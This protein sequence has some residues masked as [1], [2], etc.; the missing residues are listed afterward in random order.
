MSCREECADVLVLQIILGVAVV[1]VPRPEAQLS[2][3][4]NN[5]TT[6]NILPYSVLAY[7][8]VESILQEVCKLKWSFGVCGI[9][10][11]EH[12]L[13]AREQ[14]A[15]QWNMSTQQQVQAQLQN[16]LQENIVKG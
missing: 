6:T 7:I 2:S 4:K 13:E 16:Q 1:V 8:I 14:K 5:C 12:D 3:F 9:I 15:S 10:V 11:I